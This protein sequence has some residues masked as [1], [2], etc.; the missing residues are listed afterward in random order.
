MSQGG[1][2]SPRQIAGVSLV[3]LGMLGVLLGEFSFTKEEHSV[4][5]VE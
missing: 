4:E 3:A 5:F 1:A 2:V